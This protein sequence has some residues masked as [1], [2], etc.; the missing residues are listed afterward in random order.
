M[1]LH[2]ELAS[3]ICVG[4]DSHEDFNR[5]G[6]S[7]RNFLKCKIKVVLIVI[8]A[9]AIYGCCEIK[10][11]WVLADVINLISSGEYVSEQMLPISFGNLKIQSGSFQRIKINDKKRKEPSAVPPVDGS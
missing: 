6:N 8:A 2:R 10:K 7:L 5:I 1:S 11:T 4:G 3:S 9:I